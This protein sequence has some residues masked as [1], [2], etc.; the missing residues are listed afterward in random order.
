M[1]SITSVL[2]N[3]FDSSQFFSPGEESSGEFVNGFTDGTS[4]GLSLVNKEGTRMVSNL[5]IGIQEGQPKAIKSGNDLATKIIEALK[6]YFDKFKTTGYDSAL[7]YAEGLS[8][9]KG[10]AETAAKE[11]ADMITKAFKKANDQI[12][13]IGENAG[14]GF[15][16]GLKSKLEDAANIAADIGKAT[17]NAT[18]KSLDE[19]SPSKIMGK[20]GDNAG[21]GYINSL[22]LYIAKAAEVGKELG[23]ETV[24]GISIVMDDI[25]DPV[26]RPTV[27]LTNVNNSF[28]VIRERFNDA[29]STAATMASSISTTMNV[30][31]TRKEET[32]QPKQ[33][34][35]NNYNMEQN[36]YSPKALSSVDI[37]RQ[38][39]NQFSRF[40]SSIN[41]K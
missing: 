21:L 31:D 7:K 14:T 19:H 30:K 10:E 26:I 16:N 41:N 33:T 18:A 20:I 12:I 1:D 24:E 25:H 35:V 36:N 3:G 8:N 39:N 13:S 37:Y 28:D 38:T 4:D 40:K 2:T 15:V 27:D 29:I 34:V 17:S 11:F 6:S 32:K 22:M 23:E 9:A 5:V